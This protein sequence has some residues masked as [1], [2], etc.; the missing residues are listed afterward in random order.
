MIPPS[1]ISSDA[2]ERIMLEIAG[3]LHGFAV[4]ASTADD[5]LVD[6][7]VALETGPAIA[8]SDALVCR[9]AA[10]EMAGFVAMMEEKFVSSNS[11]ED[12][13]SAIVDMPPTTAVGSRCRFV[14]RRDNEGS[15]LLALQTC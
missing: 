10:V 14:A 11:M 2:L 3:T 15:M 9:A 5:S 7:L 4:H 12:P 13:P 8:D 6:L 1:T